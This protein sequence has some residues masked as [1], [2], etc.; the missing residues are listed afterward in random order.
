MSFW[1]NQNVRSKKCRGCIGCGQV[2]NV[3][4]IYHRSVG[5]YEGDFQNQAWHLECV[6]QFYKDSKEFD[7]NSI[8]PGEHPR[9]FVHEGAG[10]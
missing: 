10:I 7:D 9:P 6:E 1:R 3:G 2:I 5:I 8:F 4:E